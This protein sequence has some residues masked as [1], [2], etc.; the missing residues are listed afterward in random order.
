MEIIDTH[1]HIYDKNDFGND[2]EEVIIRMKKEGITH[3]ILPNID[4]NTIPDLL[5]FERRDP[6]HF[7]CLMGLHPENIKE[8]YKKELNCILEEFDNHKYYGVGEIGIDLYWDQSHL[9]EQIEAFEAQ[10]DYASKN[11]LPI[12]IHCRN[13]FKEIQNCLSEFDKNKI[14]GI[15]HSFTGTKDEYEEIKN[16]GDFKIGINGIITFKNSENLRKAIKE[17]PLSD[18]VLETDAPYLAPIPYRG[19]RNESSFIVKVA[20][21]IADIKEM[22]IE[23]VAKE[24]SKNAKVVFS[25]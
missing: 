17:I 11:E 18:I 10:V 4:L 6:N 16:L 7:H 22:D 8:N 9:K 24:T 23:N 21:K 12:I 15:F 3:V 14:F 20:E 1:T 5:D 13:G 2:Q 25:L 19:K